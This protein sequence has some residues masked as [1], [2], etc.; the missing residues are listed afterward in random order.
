LRPLVD[1]HLSR[2]LAE[3]LRSRG[4]DVVA[5]TEVGLAGVDD[6][7]VLSWA[8]RERRAVVTNNIQDFRPLHVTYL[9]TGTVHYGI[10]LVP[11]GRYSFRRDRL[12]PLMAAL[13]E[14]LAQR[15]AEGSLCDTEYFL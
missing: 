4:H 12:G 14:F 1:E 13:E 2:V 6:P 11:S 15:P 3:Q 5:A 10:V 9:T 8:V 7:Q